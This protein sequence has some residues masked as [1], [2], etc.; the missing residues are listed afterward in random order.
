MNGR[1]RMAFPVVAMA[2]AR[3]HNAAMEGRL[4]RSLAFLALAVTGAALA[5]ATTAP[6]ATASASAAAGGAT[7]TLHRC[8]DARGKVTW[9]DDA[10]PKGS[11]DELRQMVRPVDAPRRR[12][13][14]AAEVPA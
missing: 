14:P 1:G 3:S 7:V 10:C 6:V 12:P 5:P 9:Q 2:S 11:R 4:S 13:A 8:T